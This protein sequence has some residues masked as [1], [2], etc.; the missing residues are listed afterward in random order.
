MKKSGR[1]T[2]EQTN[3]QPD[4]VEN[5]SHVEVKTSK[6]V[7]KVLVQGNRGVTRIIC[8]LWV[9]SSAAYAVQTASY[10]LSDKYSTKNEKNEKKAKKKFV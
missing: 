7:V 6:K 9:E 5:V 8:N 1:R 3:R 10:Y 2:D 4:E